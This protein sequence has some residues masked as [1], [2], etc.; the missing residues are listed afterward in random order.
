MKKNN[1]PPVIIKLNLAKEGNKKPK[2]SPTKKE[3]IMIPQN[4]IFESE[5]VQIAN[6]NKAHVT[7]PV[8]NPI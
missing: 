6:K 7:N 4:L 5:P 1:K 2:V 8:I 3:K